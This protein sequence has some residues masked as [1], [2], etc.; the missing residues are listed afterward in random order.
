MGEIPEK[1]FARKKWLKNK[2]ARVVER[3]KRDSCGGQEK[4]DFKKKPGKKKEK[5]TPQIGSVAIATAF[6]NLANIE[7]ISIDDSTLNKVEN[8]GALF[9]ACKDCTTVSG[10]LSTCFLYL[11]THYTKSVANLAAQYLSEVLGAEFDSQLGEFGVKTEDKPKWLLLLKDL[12]ENW[13]LVVR[14]EGFKKI[15]HVLSLSLALGLCESADLDFKIGGMKLFS[16]GALTKHASAVDLIDAVFE[17]VTYFAE[18]G[19]TCFQRGSIKPL[20]YGNMENEEFEEL[21]SKCL[22]CQEYAKCGNLE[23]YEDMSENDY[24]ALLAQCIEKANMLVT[25]SRGPLRRIFFAGN[26]IL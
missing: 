16:I 2:D 23:K 25:T 8:L 19:Y 10:F 22:R 7:G 20:L 6:A 26:L 1:A 15:S 9:L 17:T 14:N 3:T 4:K 21:Y 13:T 5:F 12:Q 18:G 24:E 11:K